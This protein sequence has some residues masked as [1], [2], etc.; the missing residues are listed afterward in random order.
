MEAAA[1][2]A[3]DTGASLPER[4]EAL[5]DLA[6]GRLEVVERSY[7]MA[8]RR[9]RIRFAGSAMFDII[10]RAFGHL[11][12][13]SGQEPEL[14]ID[15]WDSASSGTPKPP[16]PAAESDAA[17][18]S[19]Y[20][21]GD[22]RVQAHFQPASGALT[23]IDLE[24]NHAWYWFNDAADLPDWE[25][26][27]SIRQILH[28]W[29]PQHGVF[30]LHG[31]AIGTTSGGVLLVGRGGSGKSTTALSSLEV[32]GM[33]YV[34][35][36]Y[37]GVRV[38]PEPYVYSLYSAGKLVPGHAE[39]LPHLAEAAANADRFHAEDKAVFYAHELY[40]NRV[41]AGFPLRAVLL[42]KIT[43]RVETRLVP[44]APTAALAAL[45]PSTMLQLHPPSNAAWKAMGQLVRRIPSF[46]LE[47]GSDIP[48]IPRT[49]QRFIGEL[50]EDTA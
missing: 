27:A 20:Y 14:T 40:P 41:V 12:D 16:L 17:Y 23:V 5:V 26:A 42:P 13:D 3:P 15:V 10:G 28:W 29:L 34:G 24:R 4:L 21:Y 37:V 47:L 11:A 32:P 31:G 18:G 2:L 46:Q 43:D 38:A 30:E 48:A 45:A 49:I 6:A 50:D 44:V 36:D 25:R 9:V 8:D 19:K 35:D 39:R 22:S 33:R 1:A 7:L